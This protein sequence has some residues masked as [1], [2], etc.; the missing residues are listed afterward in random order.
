MTGTA[1][2]IE[3]AEQIG[4]RVDDEFH[5]VANAFRCAASL[6]ARN[7]PARRSATGCRAID[8]AE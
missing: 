4:S 3:W 5:R 2:Q 7:A 6:Q 1:S 8:K